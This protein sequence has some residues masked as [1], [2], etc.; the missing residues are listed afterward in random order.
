MQYT[1][2]KDLIQSKNII[3]IPQKYKIPVYNSTD[4]T[5]QLISTDPVG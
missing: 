3:L 2:Y 4:A 5:T 1:R